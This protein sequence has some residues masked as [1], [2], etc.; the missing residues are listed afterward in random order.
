MP[1]TYLLDE[2]LR[3]PLWR[4][5]QWHNLRG[6]CPLDVVRVGDPPDLPL[7][8]ADPDILL[9]AERAGRILV[10][11]DRKTMARHLADHLQAGHQ[12]PG[13]FTIRQLTPLP[14][15]IEF[16]VLVAYESE[17][18]EWQDRIEYLP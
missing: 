12:S 13:I 11:D 10:S 4:A 14:Q 18:H 8:T 9:W 1:R 15:V 6:V 17:A 5:I 3:G 7:G 16:L 2:H